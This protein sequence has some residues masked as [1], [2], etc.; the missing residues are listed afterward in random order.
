MA[1]RLTDK[2]KKKII[3]DYV[4]LGSYNAAAKKNGVSNHTVKRIVLGVPEIA[5]K[6]QQKKDENTR[7]ILAYMESQRDDVCE[8]LR[9]AMEHLKN[10]EKLEK[11]Q[12]QQVAT[13][14]AII[15]DKWTAISGGPADTAREDELSKSLKEM[16]KELESDG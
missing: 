11:A 1:A 3:A 9:L 6:V 13:T 12:L 14:M 4:Q 7:D 16:G 5:D 15:I 2:Q 8:F 10:P